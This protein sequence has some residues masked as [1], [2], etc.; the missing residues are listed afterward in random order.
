MNDN[1]RRR[2]DESDDRCAIDFLCTLGAA[3]TAHSGRTLAAHLIG[4]YRIL[5]DWRC[6]AHVL[7][8]GLYHSVYGT[9]AFERRLVCD[10]EAIGRRIG[11]AA[12]ALVYDYSQ[13]QHGEFF[14]WAART[15]HAE[16]TAT[17][18]AGRLRDAGRDGYGLAH[19]IVANELELAWNSDLDI[20]ARRRIATR[21][22]RNAF[23]M[24]SFLSAPALASLGRLLGSPLTRP[25][26]AEARCRSQPDRSARRPQA[27]ARRSDTT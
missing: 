20:V 15:G 12:E 27:R 22:A 4:T 1:L 5:R 13:M 9:P 8:A 3:R 25:R 24:R 11:S 6:P 14:D 26:S 18:R 23:A 21:I 2:N 16:P 17:P 19:L 7:T 10:R